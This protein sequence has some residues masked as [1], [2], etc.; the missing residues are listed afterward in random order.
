[1]ETLALI[2]L[3]NVREF[4]DD[5]IGELDKANLKIIYASAELAIELHDAQNLK[6]NQTLDYTYHLAMVFKK[7]LDYIRLI[8]TEFQVK[9]LC[10]IWLHDVIEDCITYNALIDR[11]RGKKVPFHYA[12]DIADFAFGV[13]NAT[14]KDR[15]DR[16]LLTYPKIRSSVYFVY[17]K[18]CD[19][20]ANTYHSLMEGQGWAKKH[21]I[22][23]PHFRYFLNEYKELKPLWD[24]LDKLNKFKS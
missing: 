2:K 14:G 10:A 7:G 17:I 13:T 16:A 18:C 6:Y 12:R 23:Y 24:D 11:L 1:M 19:R 9:I 15:K 8:P 21:A 3:D 4:I 5:N 22:E 20:W